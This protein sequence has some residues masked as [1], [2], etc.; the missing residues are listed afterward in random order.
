M[1]FNKNLPPKF[2]QGYLAFDKN[3]LSLEITF[4]LCTDK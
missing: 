1:V 3:V 4:G 2:N